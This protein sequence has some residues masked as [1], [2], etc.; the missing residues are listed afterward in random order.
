MRM[1]KNKIF[2]G[3]FCVE[4]H[5]RNRLMVALNISWEKPGDDFTSHYA[6]PIRNLISSPPS[7]GSIYLYLYVMVVGIQI[8]RI[9]RYIHIRY[10]RAR[11]AKNKKVVFLFY[12]PF[13]KRRWLVA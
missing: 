5:G 4:G 13:G 12:S 1:E 9:A 7:I 10:S 3:L 11:F 2:L 8:P 6:T